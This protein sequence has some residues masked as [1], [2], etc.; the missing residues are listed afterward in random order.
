M[1]RRTLHYNPKRKIFTEKST[2]TLPRLLT[3]E[4][5]VLLQESEAS[6]PPHGKAGHLTVSAMMNWISAIGHMA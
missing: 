6:N 2:Y 4:E 5:E 1:E 3:P